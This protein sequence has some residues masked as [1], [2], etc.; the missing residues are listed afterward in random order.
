MDLILQRLVKS[1]KIRGDR[2]IVWSKSNNCEEAKDSA[3]EAVVFA[4]RAISYAR[5]TNQGI[6][7]TNVFSWVSVECTNPECSGV[8]SA[9]VHRGEEST[10]LCTI[11]AID[12]AC[13][14]KE[15]LDEKGRE[16][17]VG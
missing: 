10:A 13:K 16:T 14:K 2:A 7:G 9:L 5:D 4:R 3:I 8:L 6:P 1:A 15:L 12:I 17:S 11:C